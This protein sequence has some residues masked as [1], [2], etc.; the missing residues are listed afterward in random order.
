MEKRE[1]TAL[2]LLPLAFVIGY[3]VL[4]QVIWQ[5]VILAGERSTMTQTFS[6]VIGAA[7][8]LAIACV[9]VYGHTRVVGPLTVQRSLLMAVISIPMLML[10]HV[11]TM[12]VSGFVRYLTMVPFQAV[13]H[14]AM[15]FCA[16][17]VAT[18]IMGPGRGAP[19]PTGAVPDPAAPALVSPPATVGVILLRVAVALVSIGGFLGTGL[20]FI[21]AIGFG[22]FHLSGQDG[23]FALALIV[24]LVLFLFCFLCAVG[25]F[26]RIM[27]IARFVVA[28][29]A[30]PFIGAFVNEGEEFVWG[31][32]AVAAYVGA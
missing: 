27:K 2:W 8:A 29:I 16:L 30:V 13:L 18:A 4:A 32:V 17:P 1:A 24:A 7:C 3:R 31:A 11:V 21:F 20:L 19:T 15:V 23:L 26:R 14:Y 22:G 5:L 10:G 9:C 25:L 28:A 12:G 6:F